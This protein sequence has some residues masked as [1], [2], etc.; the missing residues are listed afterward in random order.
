[1][2]KKKTDNYK[3]FEQGPIRPP[4]EANSL[5]IRLTRNCPWNN[6]TFCRVYKKRKFS[7]RSVENITRDIDFLQSY[8]QKIKEIVKP[9]GFV[10]NQVINSLYNDFDKKDRGAFNAAI[11]WYASGMKSIFLQDANSLIMKPDDLVS[12]LE[13]IKKCFPEVD[14]IT[15]YARSHTIARIKQDDLQRIADA[16]LNRIHVGMESGSDIVL[17][18]IKKGA[19]KATHI[20]AGLKV[21][22][23]GMELSEYVM[24][25]LG[26]IDYSI[27]HALETAS[28]LNSI[29]PDFIRIRTLAVTNGTVLAQEVKSGEFEK[30]NDAMMAKELRLLI[31]SLDGID[32]YIKSDHIL[33]LF[34]TI[35]GKM[36]E[37]KEK[38]I[39]IIDRFFELEPEKRILYQVGRRMGF[40][41]G[42]DDMDNSPHIERVKKACT[43]YGVTPENIDSVIDELMKRFV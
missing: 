22:Q 5:L 9:G 23:A 16:G 19:D 39:G 21:K 2:K 10:D 27:E 33:N 37:D 34:E 4:S 13:H 26:G 35:N 1:M 12:V 11:N 32:S 30:P 43:L 29:N 40:F 38:M 15:S 14:R 6:C 18:K 24:P 8:I 36:P 41:R 7:L 20:K 3:G 31:E 17:K 28:A 42:P 25:G